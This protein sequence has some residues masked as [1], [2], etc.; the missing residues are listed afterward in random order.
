MSFLN[1]MT[2]TEMMLECDIQASYIVTK[3]HPFSSHRLY[4]Q[5]FPTDPHTWS[6]LITFVSSPRSKWIKLWI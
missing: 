3:T 6:L 2:F 5:P 4:P 1:R